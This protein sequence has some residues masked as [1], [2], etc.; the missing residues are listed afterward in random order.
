M[1]WWWLVMAVGISSD[2]YNVYF[3][4]DWRRSDGWPNVEAK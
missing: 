3:D 1:N 2:G 4:D